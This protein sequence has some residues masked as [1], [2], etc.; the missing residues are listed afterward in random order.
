[1]VSTHKKS[2]MHSMQKLWK[3]L[4][5]HICAFLIDRMIGITYNDLEKCKNVVCIAYGEAKAKPI[6]G[7]IRGGFINTLIIDSACGEKLLEQ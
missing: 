4:E 5:L 6:A 2:R 3:M 7:A 1:M